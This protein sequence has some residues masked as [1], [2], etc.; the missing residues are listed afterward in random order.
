[1]T[2][3]FWGLL[4]HDI[5]ST[6]QNKGH[7]E[8]GASLA[9]EILKELGYP[10]DQIHLVQ[11]A[12]RFHNEEEI[13]V[14]SRSRVLTDAGPD[15]VHLGEGLNLSVPLGPARNLYKRLLLTIRRFY[16]ARKECRYLRAM[17]RRLWISLRMMPLMYLLRNVTKDLDPGHYLTNAAK[18]EASHPELLERNKAQ[19]LKFAE[20]YAP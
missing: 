6:A 13:S 5:T 18:E 3:L 1:M 20:F 15:A 16:H 8:S 9:D 11:D 4:F 2:S 14:F 10:E 12:V 19:L 7:E 17:T